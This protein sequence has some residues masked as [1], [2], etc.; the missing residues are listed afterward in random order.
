MVT[1]PKFQEIFLGG[2]CAAEMQALVGGQVN[3][4]KLGALLNAFMEIEELRTAC[5][6]ISD[7]ELDLLADVELLDLCSDSREL[8][9]GS[10]FV[11]L[12]GQIYRAEDT[13][14]EAVNKGA[15]AVIA[16]GVAPRFGFYSNACSADRIPLIKLPRLNERLSR[17]ASIFLNSKKTMDV[18]GVTGTNGKTTCAWMLAKAHASFDESA[19][20]VGTLGYGLLGVDGDSELQSTGMTTPDAIKTQRILAE[21]ASMDCSVVAMEVSSHALSQWRV[22]AVDIK[23]AI[24]TNLSHDHLDY[25]SSMDEYAAAKIELFKMN[26]VKYAVINLD[27]PYAHRFISSLNP[28]ATYLTYSTGNEKADVRALKAEFNI[29]GIFAQIHTPIGELDLNLNLIGRFNLSNALAV[30]AGLLSNGKT[31]EQIAVAIQLLSPPPGRAQRIG[32]RKSTAGEVS[33]GEEDIVA[34]VDFAHTPD[35][36]KNILR[37][38]KEHCVGELWCVFGCGGDRDKLKRAEMA[39]VAELEADRVVVT[40]DNSRSEDPAAIFAD[41]CQGF[42]ADFPVEIEPERK[43]A[44]CNAVLGAGAGDVVLIAGKGHEQFIDEA[45]KRIPFLDAE[46]VR[47]ALELRMGRAA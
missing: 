43:Q 42:S 47:L 40:R 8:V 17:I 29:G 11:A 34:V 44:I 25:H 39:R 6:A 1:A 41:I 12:E 33:V 26:S 18:F 35:A 9:A 5:S 7:K 28:R 14:V 2:A 36:L 37:A 21:L 45:G 16:E 4:W 46:Q 13:I 30:I 15:L 10:L 3:R 31:L 27:D 23:T 22:A 24:F 32:L 38:L 19:A 20:V